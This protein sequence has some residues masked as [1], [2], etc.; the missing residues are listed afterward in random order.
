MLKLG[1]YVVDR[2]PLSVPAFRHLWVA[3]AVSAV[4]GSF[5]LVAVPAQLFTLTGSSAFVGL[6]AAVSLCALTGSALW[7]GVLADSMDRGRLLLAGNAILVVTHLGLW[8]TAGFD[9]VPV[10]LVLVGAQG[11]GL[12]AT[13]TT[14]GAA[15][16]NLVPEEQLVAANSLSSLTRY[17]GAVVGPL[18]AGVLIPLT[19]VATLYL[20]DA[21]ALTTVLW[22]VARL[23]AMPPRHTTRQRLSDGFRYLAGHPILVAL[24]AVDLAAMVF[25]MPVALLPE[26]AEHTY[27][28]P[29]GGGMELGLLFA[30]YPTGVLLA[31]LL[32]GTFSRTTRHGRLMTSAAM[33]WGT[34]VVVL[35]LAADLWLALAAL[36]AGGAVNF[37]LS[38]FRNTIAQAHTDDALRGRIQGSLTVVLIGGPQLAN[39]LHGFA[40]ATF[41][42][43]WTISVGGALTVISVALLTRAVPQ[44]WH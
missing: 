36:F 38:T 11:A 8:L 2:S 10:L 41:G 6:S 24:L 26:L 35:G 29:P 7:A 19:G 40:G 21:L 18:L 34:C 44:L 42:P 25:A 5:S 32:S 39:L 28:G 13:M 14:T 37:V 12:G 23:P 9:S 27:G 4:G 17:T 43:H 15:V 30:A 31:G 1:A 22:A 33:A 20:L 3:S 16:P